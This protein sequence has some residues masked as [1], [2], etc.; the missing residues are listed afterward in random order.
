MA[1]AQFP[2][3]PVSSDDAL[4]HEAE[5]SNVVPNHTVD[6]GKVSATSNGKT[7][8]PVQY[9][10]RL[11][12]SELSYYLP[13]RATGVND[14]YLHLDFRAPEHLLRHA[15]VRMV[16]AI[17][18]GRHPLLASRVHMYEYNDVRFIYTPPQ[19]PEDAL[20]S[21][22]N[23][24]EYKSNTTRNGRNQEAP[25]KNYD[26]MICATH[27]L[28]DGMALHQFANDLFGL[29][30]SSKTQGDL[31]ALLNEEWQ[32]RWAGSIAEDSVL[33]ESMEYRFPP[34]TSKFR[35]AVGKVD[36]QRSQDELIGGQAFPRRSKQPR[37][38]TVQTVSYDVDRTK[39]ILK[40]C[41]AHG[42][43]V[44]AA[45]FAICNI[46]WAQLSQ[47]KKELPTMMYSAV[48]LRPHFTV[49]SL[50]DSYWFLAVGY[51]NVILP[52]FI[53]R[54]VE[55]STVFWHR[56]RIAKE[57]STRAAKNPMI[58][59]R[60]RL[61]AS[62]RGLRARI[63]AKEDD[64]K[65]RGLFVSPPPASTTHVKAVRAPSTALMGLS[66]LGNLDGIYKYASYPEIQFNSL[67]TGSRQRSGGMLLFS[68]TFAGK[69][70]I[71][72]GYDENGFEKACVERFWENILQATDELMVN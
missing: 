41:K 52:T 35:R 63:W 30:G 54:S 18:R 47:A 27:F 50:N 72:L 70:F 25:L 42:V 20:I 59:S 24:L 5:E 68:Y 45:L 21:A 40:R 62:E 69:L 36:F 37:H 12:E 46:A 32:A 44:S 7:S 6:I 61:M 39:A 66:L 67:T 19:S 65:D 14:M 2:P 57:Q 64:D 26:M 16:W 15:R 48:N 17:L 33:P 53:P 55:L 38:T 11:G 34:E 22:D 29:L 51:F 23:D 3:S 10:R 13:S 58:V 31:E 49:T 1:A 71:S 9:E 56:A 28:G 60:S 43:S 8:E 4:V